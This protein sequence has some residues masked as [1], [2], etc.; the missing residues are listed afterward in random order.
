M[1]RTWFERKLLP[2]IVAF[3]ASLPFMVHGDTTLKQSVAYPTHTHGLDKFILPDIFINAAAFG[4]QDNA[5]MINLIASALIFNKDYYNEFMEKTHL[6]MKTGMFVEEDD[7]IMCIRKV[8]N[9]F[10]G[11]VKAYNDDDPSKFGYSQIWVKGD[12]HVLVNEYY[13]KIGSDPSPCGPN[14]QGY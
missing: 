13:E 3:G 1:E 9:D 5:K 14:C 4:P 6:E 7:M 12:D 2:E 8:E 10:L 11:I